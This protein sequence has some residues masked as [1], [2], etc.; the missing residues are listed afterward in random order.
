MV[1]ELFVLP[2]DWNCLD[3]RRHYLSET[4]EI[5]VRRLSMH[6]KISNALV[7]AFVTVLLVLASAPGKCAN[8]VTLN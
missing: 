7:C 2:R 1:M 6:G 4:G 3:L 5:I 8:R